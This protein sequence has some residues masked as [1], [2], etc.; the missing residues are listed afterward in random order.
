MD[1]DKEVQ[2]WQPTIGKLI[3]RALDLYNKQ[4][5]GSYYSDPQGIFKAIISMLSYVNGNNI[6]NNG[7]LHDSIKD[8]T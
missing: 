2:R 8:V 3:S 5:F 4:R 7:A 6:S 1:Q